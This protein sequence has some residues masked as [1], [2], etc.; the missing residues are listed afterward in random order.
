MNTVGTDDLSAPIY[1]VAVLVLDMWTL[2]KTGASADGAI[3]LGAST[4]DHIRATLGCAPDE[5]SDIYAPVA[6]W[7]MRYGD[8][9]FMFNA[10]RVLQAVSFGGDNGE[11][12]PQAVEATAARYDAF[13]E[14]RPPMDIWVVPEQDDGEARPAV[15]RLCGAPASEF[16]ALPYFM[17]RIPADTAVRYFGMPVR[18]S[19]RMKAEDGSRNLTAEFI[20]KAYKFDYSEPFHIDYCLH[21]LTATD[22]ALVSG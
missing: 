16:A 13:G 11:R 10:A 2:F 18:K 19:V 22:D 14:L 1:D 20:L 5:E 17:N 15:L 9:H 21:T 12:I 6:A 3:S 7:W 8:T 4:P